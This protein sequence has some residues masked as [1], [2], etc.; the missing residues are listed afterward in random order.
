MKLQKVLPLSAVLVGLA[1]LPSVAGSSYVENS[2]RL[3][4]ITD[5]TSTTNVDVAEIYEG[6][7]TASSNAVKTEWGTTT[8]TEANDG[9]TFDETESFDIEATSSSS[10]SGHF[11]KT[12]DV[13]V[14]ETYHFTGFE[15]DHRV[16]S[17]YD[18]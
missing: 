3:R 2:Y 15:K 14:T 4:S 8:V 5:G 13:D 1:A 11:S 18:F 12:T 6:T 9:R 17:G 16:T 10:E 7:R